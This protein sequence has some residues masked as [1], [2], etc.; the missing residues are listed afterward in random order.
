MKRYSRGSAAFLKEVGKE[1]V[2]GG[3]RGIGSDMRMVLINLAVL[4]LVVFALALRVTGM[5]QPVDIDEYDDF[6]VRV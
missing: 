2:V 4:L 5:W 6:T 3:G 1:E